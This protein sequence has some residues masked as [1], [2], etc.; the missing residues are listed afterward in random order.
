MY[1]TCT[2]YIYYTNLLDLGLLVLVQRLQRLWRIA[3]V[4]ESHCRRTR[5]LQLGVGMEAGVR[6][7][8]VE[9]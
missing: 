6:I 8:M 7:M 5:N 9:I 2:T 4:T 3:H 1:S